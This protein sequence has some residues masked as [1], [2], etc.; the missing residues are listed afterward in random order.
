MEYLQESTQI[1]KHTLV[2]VQEVVI[3]QYEIAKKEI[4]GKIDDS[5]K[6]KFNLSENKIEATNIKNEKESKGQN[7]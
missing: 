7:C 2:L 4:Q 5:L 1:P 6:V 3:P